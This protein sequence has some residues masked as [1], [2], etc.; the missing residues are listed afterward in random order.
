MIESIKD[1]RIA[2]AR[3]LGSRAGRLAAG[4]CLVE[5]LSLI[6]QVL[7]A[8]EVGGDGM[9][10]A[11]AERGECLVARVEDFFLGT[12]DLGEIESLMHSKLGNSRP[13]PD[14]ALEVRFI[15]LLVVLLFWLRPIAS[16]GWHGRGTARALIHRARVLSRFGLRVG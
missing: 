6:G 5:G 11:G 9:P 10:V 3:V 8:G 13:G 15:T 14:M 12:D 2:A 4:R 16:L 7:S 1:E